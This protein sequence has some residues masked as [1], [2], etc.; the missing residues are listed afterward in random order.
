[1]D[2]INKYKEGIYRPNVNFDAATGLCMITGESYL[3]NATDF[4]HDFVTWLDKIATESEQAIELQFQL[5][6]FNS[7]SSKG[8]RNLLLKVKELQESGNKITAKWLYPE[9]DYNDMEMEGEDL[10]DDAEVDME[11]VQMN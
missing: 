5:D 3:E 6:Y 9:D 10:R 7:S 8:L 2:W 11:I 4:Y 1:M